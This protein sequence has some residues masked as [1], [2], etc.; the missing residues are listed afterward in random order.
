M[1]KSRRGDEWSEDEAGSR[2][3]DIQ[4]ALDFE[5]FWMHI[6]I[7]KRENGL[8][9]G[10]WVSIIYSVSATTEVNIPPSERYNEDIDNGY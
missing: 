3:F 5:P 8:Q 1:A 6:R 7:Y 2:D 4:A 9:E 10:C